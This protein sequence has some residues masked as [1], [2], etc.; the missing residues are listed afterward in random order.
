MPRVL[1]LVGK[2]ISQKDLSWLHQYFETYYTTYPKG[3]FTELSR[4]YSGYGLYLDS[5]VPG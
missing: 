4:F 3:E 5:P 1:V 2:T